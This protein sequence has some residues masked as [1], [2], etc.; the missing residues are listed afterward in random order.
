[1]VNNKYS[2]FV[3]GINELIGRVSGG[4]KKQ[5]ARDLRVNYDTVRC[6]CAGEYLPGGE[7]L[8]LLHEKYNVSID[9]LLTGKDPSAVFMDEWSPEVRRACSDVKTIME[10]GHSEDIVALSAN[11]RA[12]KRDLE[13]Y[14]EKLDINRLEKDM[15][16]LKS[17]LNDL[18]RQEKKRKLNGE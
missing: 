2:A 12:L 6:W 9:Y 11:I 17:F 4:N 14:S 8:L 18:R 5:F 3:T 7:T 1:M 13:P 16:K 15:D 10:Q